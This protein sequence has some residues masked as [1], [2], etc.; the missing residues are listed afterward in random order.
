MVE[1]SGKEKHKRQKELRVTSAVN[2][3]FA[4]ALQTRVEAI[5]N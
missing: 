3:A 2:A 1:M 4:S 5:A